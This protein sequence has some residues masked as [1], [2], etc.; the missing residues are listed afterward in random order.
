[1][2]SILGLTP[3]P[4]PLVGAGSIATTPL[5]LTGEI[6][7][8]LQEQGLPVALNYSGVGTINL[9]DTFLPDTPDLAVAVMARGGMAPLT[10]LVGGV[11]AGP[12][13]AE[14]KL[15]RPNVQIMTRCDAG[16]YV[17]GNALAEAVFGALQ[18]VGEETLNPPDGAYFHWIFALQSPVYLGQ[19][20]GR[21]RHLWSQNFRVLWDNDQR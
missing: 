16:D 11:G 4:M 1:L 14:G 10:T 2:P 9:F 20:G 5:G 17:T 13:V 8:Y 18:G 6:C 7:T 12:R 21:E 19:M 3:L 15:D